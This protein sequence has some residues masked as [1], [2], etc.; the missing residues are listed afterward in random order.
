LEAF[1]SISYASAVVLFM[2]SSPPL[3]LLKLLQ[4]QQ[5]SLFTLISYPAKFVVLFILFVSS[6][7][8]SRII[9]F[10]AR[11]IS[12]FKWCLQ[13]VGVWVPDR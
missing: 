8:S 2:P 11:C 4:L 13:A 3:V 7:T 10:E 9:V 1:F 6:P 5:E 12:C